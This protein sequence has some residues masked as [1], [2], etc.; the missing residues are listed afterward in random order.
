MYRT[1]YRSPLWKLALMAML[2][3]VSGCATSTSA[4]HSTSSTTSVSTMPTPAPTATSVPGVA[5]TATLMPGDT[6]TPFSGYPPD[7]PMAP[8]AKIALGGNMATYSPEAITQ[9][10]K[11]VLVIEGNINHAYAGPTAAF[12]WA[13]GVGWISIPG[14]Q[15]T[16]INL[17]GATFSA[18]YTYTI[19]LT[20]TYDVI[21]QFACI[22]TSFPCNFGIAIPTK[23]WA[24]NPTTAIA[25]VVFPGVALT[26][27]VDQDVI[28]VNDPVHGLAAA[29]LTTNTVT[30]LHGTVV[31]SSVTLSV[32]AFTW[33]Y[34]VYATRDTST[35]VVTGH[36]Y[37]LQTQVDVTL[38]QI[39]SV[40]Q[41]GSQYL[42]ATFAIPAGS[43]T[44]FYMY[45]DLEELDHLMQPGSVPVSLYQEN[46]TINATII[47]A[48][49]QMVLVASDG[50]VGMLWDRL[51][52]QAYTLYH[53]NGP[54]F[55]YG[56]AT[57][58]WFGV[59]PFWGGAA[60][61]GFGADPDPISFALYATSG[62]PA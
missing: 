43:D 4:S 50:D 7:Y 18:N 40:L 17:P 13:I 10:G 55:D 21:K 26:T 47:G 54:A 11:K 60:A 19:Q 42:T 46:G 32:L 39:A 38:P 48:T 16:A 36:A 20:D 56:I 44:L 27:F 61:I 6:P 5:P 24:Y 1:Y 2:V 14:D 31:A 58:P 3:L 12:N 30:P 37:D 15:Y 51:N 28:I 53:G 29:N 34:L 52:H 8:L 62:V 23:V 22:G 33:P 57:G 45:T 9:D 35:H 25:H 59:V 41:P 49:A